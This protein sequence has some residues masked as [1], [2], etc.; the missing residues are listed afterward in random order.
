LPVTGSSGSIPVSLVFRFGFDEIFSA[1]GFSGVDPEVVGLDVAPCAD[2]DVD[3]ALDLDDGAVFA[4][5][6][7]VVGLPV[8][9]LVGLP[10]IVGVTAAAFV[11]F[12]VLCIVVGLVGLLVLCIV[13]GATG[14][15]VPWIVWG[16]TGLPEVVGFTTVVGLC[17][18]AGVVADAANAGDNVKDAAASKPG[19]VAETRIGTS[20]NAES[21]QA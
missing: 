5:D 1:I 17:D 21:R 14:L 20:Q 16:A 11:G 3:V 12:T 13:G 6:V 18:C 2:L 4:P 9:A 15:L 10:L 19:I 8:P 7:S